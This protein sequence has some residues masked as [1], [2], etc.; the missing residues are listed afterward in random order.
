[1]L[2][3]EEEP[4]DKPIAKT[5]EGFYESDVIGKATWPSEEKSNFSEPTTWLGWGLGTIS[6]YL[7]S[8][9]QAIEN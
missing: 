1:V 6:S 2:V 7:W 9:E 8:G 4:K 3:E 5:D